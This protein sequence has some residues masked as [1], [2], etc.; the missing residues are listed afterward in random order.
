M[1]RRLLLP[2]LVTAF[3]GVAPSG[4]DPAVPAGLAPS[5]A[6]PAM[7]RYSA[8]GALVRPDGVDRW[9]LVGASL[10]LGYSNATDDGVGMFHRVYLEPSAYRHFLRTGRFRNG[11]ML[12]L[13]IRHSVRR[14]PPSR[15]GWSEGDLA[16]LELAVKDPA[17]FRGGW[18]YFDF[19]R[20][21]RVAPALPADRCARCHAEH[22]ARDNV[23]LQFYP[24][25]RA[26]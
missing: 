26:R 15:A 1:I 24:Q 19:G 17:R 10:G 22:A 6:D 23:F 12:A 5:A 4:S 2:V 16:A 14:V 7:P 20:D 18:A 25:L 8:D 3:T 21:G 9:V 11:T 13:S